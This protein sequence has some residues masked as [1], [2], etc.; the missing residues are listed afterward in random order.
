MP[1][2]CCLVSV[3]GLRGEIDV[4]TKVIVYLQ[5]LGDSAAGM[6]GQ[7]LGNCYV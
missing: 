7:N 2:Q 6:L 5:V 1:L 4:R 3:E